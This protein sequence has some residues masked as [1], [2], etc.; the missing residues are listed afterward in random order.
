MNSGGAAHILV[1]MKKILERLYD[2]A[3]RA[4]ESERAVLWLCAI[5]F[6]GSIFFPLPTEVIMIPMMFARPKR[7]FHVAS[8]ALAASIAG[9][10]AAY[11]IGFLSAPIGNAILG[12]FGYSLADFAAAYEKWGYWFVFAG[13]LTPFPYKII[14]VA[15]GMVAMDPAIFISA[16]LVSRATRYYLI[17]WGIFAF[18]ERARK[19]VEKHLELI[20]VALFA[21]LI[22]GALAMKA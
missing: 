1:K 8:L 2:F 16:S 10:I 6:F 12:W 22:A 7:S 3:L 13:G 11:Y 9:G 19:F 20:S 15:S 17:A 4:S 14:C 21:L 5:S 18:G